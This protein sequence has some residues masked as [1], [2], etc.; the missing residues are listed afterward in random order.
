MRSSPESP[1]L[2]RRNV[3]PE[4]LCNWNLCLNN[5]LLAIPKGELNLSNCSNQMAKSY[6]LERRRLIGTIHRSTQSDVSFN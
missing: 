1:S 2:L 5:A 6:G 3:L 4:L